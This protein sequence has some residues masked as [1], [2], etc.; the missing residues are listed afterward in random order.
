MDKDLRTLLGRRVR[1][2]F[3]TRFC[4]RGD[5]GRCR[6]SILAALGKAGDELAA[7]QGPDPALW[8][9]DATKERLSFA[10]GIVTT[11]LAWTNRPS[12]IQQVISFDGHRL[13]GARRR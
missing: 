4:G 2:R 7:A 9:A 13:R 8:R 12:G 10:P 11:T 5:L 6:A 3:A 1:G